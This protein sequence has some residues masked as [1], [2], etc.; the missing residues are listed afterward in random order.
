MPHVGAEVILAEAQE[1]PP[2]PQ[3]RSWLWAGVKT[4]LKEGPMSLR[5]VR[6][7]AIVGVAAVIALTAS[8]LVVYPH[9]AGGAGGAIYTA[10]LAI[11]LAGYLAT[12][13]I[14]TAGAASPPRTEALR[15][16][17]LAGLA[18]AALLT[19]G[20]QL[21][22][23]PTALLLL[24]A[25]AA[26]PFLAALKAPRVETGLWSGMTAALVNLAIGMALT[27]VFP[28]RVPLDD[29]VLSNNHTAADILAANIGEHLVGYVA[30][31]I[32]GPLLGVLF[33][34]IGTAAGQGSGSTQIGS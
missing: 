12:A 20:L 17:S 21:P 19:F 9:A 26:V 14:L 34:L 27:L 16:G 31:L 4:M 33:G 23:A 7:G 13:W 10:L 29:D 32:V 30:F 18:S 11:L 24:L 5:A 3:R 15:I 1:L 6:I 8:I 25:G 22:V 2:G 28:S